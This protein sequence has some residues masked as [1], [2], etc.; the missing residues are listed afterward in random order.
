MSCDRGARACWSAGYS[1]FMRLAPPQCLQPLCRTMRG[2]GRCLGSL[3]CRCGGPGAPVYGGK[4]V[5]NCNV[6]SGI[7]TVPGCLPTVAG[8]CG[9]PACWQHR[10]CTRICSFCA[11]ALYGTGA[12]SMRYCAATASGPRRCERCAGASPSNGTGS[13]QRETISIKIYSLAKAGWSAWLGLCLLTM[14]TELR[15]TQGAAIPGARSDV[16]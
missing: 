1:R 14:P 16:W 8:T 15:G 7:P 3:P 6:W 5:V 11:F 2:H 9:G 12:G 10:T 13:R 4:A